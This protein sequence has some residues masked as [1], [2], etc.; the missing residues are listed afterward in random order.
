MKSKNLRHNHRQNLHLCS[1]ADDHL[2]NAE[3][4]THISEPYYV[5]VVL[6][7]RTLSE[8]IIRYIF[9]YFKKESFDLSPRTIRRLKTSISAG[10]F[11]NFKTIYDTEYMMWF[12]SDY[13]EY[14]EDCCNYEWNFYSLC[15]CTMCNPIK[16]HSHL[17]IEQCEC[18]DGK[19]YLAFKMIYREAYEFLTI[20]NK[21]SKRR[22]RRH[23]DLITN[24]YQL[25]VNYILASGP[26]I[27]NHSEMIIREI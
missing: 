16:V 10:N 9:A 24:E 22:R 18:A 8:D 21:K 5:A 3:Y 17:Y 14:G 7:V 2:T 20:Y 23:P 19:R 1:Q 4:I 6:F 26:I 12:I 15:S 13:F 25:I 11:E 27:L